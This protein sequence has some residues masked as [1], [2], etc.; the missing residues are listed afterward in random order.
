MREGEN[1]LCSEGHGGRQATEIMCSAQCKA[2][3]LCASPCGNLKPHIPALL[4]IPVRSVFP[5][6]GWRWVDSAQGQD[7]RPKRAE[8]CLGGLGG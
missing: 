7:P 3:R 1:N 5:L 6:Q 4:S 8:S 2:A